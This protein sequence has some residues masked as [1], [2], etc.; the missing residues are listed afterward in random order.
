LT[1]SFASAMRSLYVLAI[2]DSSCIGVP[3]AD[4]G[5]RSPSRIVF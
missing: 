2:E 4:G 1:D 3:A 5:G